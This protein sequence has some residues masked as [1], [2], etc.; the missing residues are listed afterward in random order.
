MELEELPGGWWKA[1]RI[2]PPF[3]RYAIAETPEKAAITLEMSTSYDRLC[4]MLES[5][6]LD[7]IQH[8]FEEYE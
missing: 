6:P 4:E 2:R 5:L 7:P 8:P 1:E 3:N